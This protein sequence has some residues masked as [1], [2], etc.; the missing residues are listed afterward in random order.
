MLSD[1]YSIENFNAKSKSGYPYNSRK[2][3]LSENAVR[4]TGNKKIQ[5][6]FVPTEEKMSYPTGSTRN[7]RGMDVRARSGLNIF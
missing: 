4:K 1:Y 3:N 7:S 2:S 5:N 6:N